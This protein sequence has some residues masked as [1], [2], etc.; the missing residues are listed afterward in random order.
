MGIYDKY[1]DYLLVYRVLPSITLLIMHT[2]CILSILLYMFGN[3]SIVINHE[4]RE[5]IELVA[6]VG[7]RVEGRGQGH[8]S[9]SKVKVK[10]LACSG[11]YYGLGFAK[12]SKGQRRVIV[13]PRCLSVCRIITWMWSID[14]QLMYSSRK[15]RIILA[16][17]LI[18]IFCWA[19]QKL[20]VPLCCQ[21]PSGHQ[22]IL[23]KA[24][25]FPNTWAQAD[26]HEHLSLGFWH[27]AAY[28]N[29]YQVSLQ[30][31]IEISHE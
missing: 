8:G 20:H 29:H 10:F 13:S 7:V 18:V 14:F 30:N 12:C 1:R 6:S 28:N 5:L 17:E 3:I 22:P 24:P 9:R 11:R 25:P 27:Q 19:S 2:V 4:A 15:D 26:T 23:F 16:L 31:I 21:N